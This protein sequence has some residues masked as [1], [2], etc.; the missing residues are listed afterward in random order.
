MSFWFFHTNT[1]FKSIIQA[2]RLQHTLLYEFSL[3]IT[4]YIC[5]DVRNSRPMVNLYW[6]YVVVKCKWINMS[7]W[8][9]QRNKVVPIYIMHHGG[10]LFF[11]SNLKKKIK[12]KIANLTNLYNSNFYRNFFFS[13]SIW[14]SKN[15]QN[16][17]FIC[18]ISSIKYEELCAPDHWTYKVHIVR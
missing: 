9:N 15:V 5:V 4:Y 14:L 17:F 7:V 12:N 10:F 1:F 2:Q 8:K 11:K 16:A 3:S 6:T 18:S 13:E